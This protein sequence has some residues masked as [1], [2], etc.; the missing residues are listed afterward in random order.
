MPVSPRG[1]IQ[2]L[3]QNGRPAQMHQFDLAGRAIGL[4]LLQEAHAV[5]A[6]LLVMGAFS[7]NRILEAVFGGATQEVLRSLDIPVLMHT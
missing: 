3:A 1:L 7:H 2:T 4:A 5:D 6:D